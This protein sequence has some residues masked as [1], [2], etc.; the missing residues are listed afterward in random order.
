M[1]SYVAFLVFLLSYQ[2]P[3]YKLPSLS[4]VSFAFHSIHSH[5]DSFQFCSNNSKH[6][7]FPKKKPL[8]ASYV[9]KNKNKDGSRCRTKWLDQKVLRS[10]ADCRCCVTKMIQLKQTIAKLC[11]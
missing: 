5:Y 7:C 10:G 9:E 1:D 6:N 11:C 8:T 2:S 4:G 3:T